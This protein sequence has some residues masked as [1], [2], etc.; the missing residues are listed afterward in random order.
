MGARVA[1]RHVLERIGDPRLR[2]YVVW[3]PILA[4]DTEE[5]AKLAVAHLPD[6]RVTHY[7][8]RDKSV[9]EAFRAPLGLA[10]GPAWDVY[11]LYPPGVKWGNGTPVP[12]YYMHQLNDR[13]PAERRFNG[14][15]LAEKVREL[16]AGKGH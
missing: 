11:L 14:A 13:L 9:A 3:A 4:D 8:T 1:Q 10:E 5:A 6:A 16:L 7:W 12:W 15:V 2:A